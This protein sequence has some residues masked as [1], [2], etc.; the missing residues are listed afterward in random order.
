MS[1]RSALPG[2]LGIVGSIALIGLLLCGL[3]SSSGRRRRL[4][5]KFHQGWADDECPVMAWY[6]Q[7]CV[8]STRFQTIEH[9]GSTEGP[10]YHEFLLLRLADGAVCRVGRTSDGPENRPIRCN[11]DAAYDCIQWFAREDETAVVHASNLLNKLKLS[12]EY[13]IMDVLAICYSI[14]NNE[15]CRVYT[16]QRYNCYFM[17]RTVMNVFK[18][19]EAN[20]RTSITRGISESLKKETRI[21]EFQDEY[22]DLGIW[23]HAQRVAAHSLTRVADSVYQDVVVTMVQVAETAPE[24]LVHRESLLWYIGQCIPMLMFCSVPFLLYMCGF[25]VVFLATRLLVIVCLV[26]L[27]PFLVL[28]LPLLFFLLIPL[29]CLFLLI[30]LLVLVPLMAAVA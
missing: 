13:D 1:Q 24:A 11:G 28:L 5:I 8:S 19:W 17:C 20:R 22:E 7:Q 21:T 4:K 12:Q 2:M 26:P 27:L 25:N 18:R 15:A 23:D 14:Q 29:L 16:L 6:H 30:P 3:A 9:R 10:F